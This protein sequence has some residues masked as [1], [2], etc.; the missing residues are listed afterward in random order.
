MQTAIGA[1][2]LALLCCGA[3]AG[4]LKANEEVKRLDQRKAALPPTS[5]PPAG[6]AG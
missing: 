3:V 4:Y 6:G 1:L 2:I 5:Q